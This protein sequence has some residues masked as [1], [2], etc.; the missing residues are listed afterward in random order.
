MISDDVLEYHKKECET[1]LSEMTDYLRYGSAKDYDDYKRVTG[2][3]RGINISLEL[4]DEAIKRSLRDEVDF[5][6]EE[7]AFNENEL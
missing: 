1:R 5:E 3:I 6:I 2:V 7:E 4:L